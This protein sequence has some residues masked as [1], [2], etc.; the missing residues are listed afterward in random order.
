METLNRHQLAAMC[1]LLEMTVFGNDQVKHFPF[2]MDVASRSYPSKFLKLISVC[3]QGRFNHI[4]HG[5]AIYFTAVCCCGCVM[6]Y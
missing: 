1:K 5:V 3:V 6:E 2:T 4:K